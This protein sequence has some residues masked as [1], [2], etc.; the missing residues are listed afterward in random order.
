[1]NKFFFIIIIL[2]LTAC[3]SDKD[4]SKVSSDGYVLFS[5]SSQ[6]ANLIFFELFFENIFLVDE[7]NEYISISSDK[8]FS[9][10]FS[11]DANHAELLFMMKVPTGL[12]QAVVVDL[13]LSQSSIKT[14][15]NGGIHTPDIY[16]VFGFNT[17]QNESLYR[18]DSNINSGIPLAI[19]PDETAYLNMALDVDASVNT[20]FID[21]QE[22]STLVI[23]PVFNVT[24]DK[25]LPSQATLKATVEHINKQE[26]SL[27]TITSDNDVHEDIMITLTNDIVYKINKGRVELDDFIDLV[28]KNLNGVAI[29]SETVE[30][31]Q[32]VNELRYLTNFPFQIFEGYIRR[33]TRFIGSKEMFMPNKI[34]YDF[35]EKAIDQID[36]RDAPFYVSSFSN[37]NDL[38]F[39]QFTVQDVMLVGSINS[40][41]ETSLELEPQSINGL[42]ASLFFDEEET[43]TILNSFNL[44]LIDDLVWFQGKFSNQ[45]FDAINAGYLETSTQRL[46]ISAPLTAEV[47]IVEKIMSQGFKINQNLGDEMIMY[48]KST[49][50]PVIDNT[51]GKIDYISLNLQP[52]S[53]TLTIERVSPVHENVS[54]IAVA[55]FLDELTELKESGY[56]LNSLIANGYLDDK[57][58]YADSLIAKVLPIDEPIDSD[59]LVAD[60]N[61]ILAGPFSRFFKS[62][63]QTFSENNR[64]LSVFPKPKK[65][66]KEKTIRSKRMV[67]DK[68]VDIFSSLDMEAYNLGQSNLRKIEQNN[69]YLGGYLSNRINANVSKELIDI[70]PEIIQL[71]KDLESIEPIKALFNNADPM[72]EFRYRILLDEY[73][74]AF[75]KGD[76]PAMEASPLHQYLKDKEKFLKIFS[77]YS[78]KKYYDEAIQLKAA[79]PTRSFKEQTTLVGLILKNDSE[80][81]KLKKLLINNPDVFKIFSDSYEQ[82]FID[83]FDQELLSQK[84]S[85]EDFFNN[86]LSFKNRFEVANKKNDMAFFYNALHKEIG[87]ISSGNTQQ[88]IDLTGQVRK[89]NKVIIESLN[90]LDIESVLN[91]DSREKLFGNFDKAVVSNFNPDDLSLASYSNIVDGVKTLSNNPQANEQASID[92]PSNYE[93][94]LLKIE[95]QRINDRFSNPTMDTSRSINNYKPKTFNIRR[96]TNSLHRSR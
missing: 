62:F 78:S 47:D 65:T 53:I 80:D 56:V 17:R 18:I 59:L 69:P 31:N 96:S 33:D 13:N 58:F 87:K 22:K 9:V 76:V 86:D 20:F 45:N 34:T 16:D 48:M 44:D 72:K 11:N 68:G 73:T 41:T 21:E 39:S 92:G 71:T 42:D 27:K 25:Q 6:N 51:Q 35:V 14:I 3:S 79:D 5:V 64:D 88:N 7:N 61:T 54:F 85:S 12:Y 89:F 63:I 94:A 37:D 83:L 55:D 15:E 82:F 10:N 67:K 23:S 81:N 95:N 29:F 26:I 1:M 24:S 91:D 19:L 90:D 8:Q 40:Q 70:V 77:G 52:K 66:K 60:E 4:K 84:L 43:M 38:A 2:L 75:A 32:W 46:T 93:N 49:H 57:T 74:S 30:D 36:S 50:S 28:K